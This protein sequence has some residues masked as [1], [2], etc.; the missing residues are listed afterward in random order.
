MQNL[1]GSRL[2]WLIRAEVYKLHPAAVNRFSKVEMSLSISITNQVLLIEM[3]TKIKKIVFLR[4]K[5]SFKS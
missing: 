5:L 4:S 3:K 2:M 1:T